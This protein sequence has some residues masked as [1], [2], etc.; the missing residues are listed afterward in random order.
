M[1][2]ILHTGVHCT[3]DDKLLKGL[4][5]NADAFRADGVAIPGPSRYRKLLSQLINTL[6]DNAPAPDAREILLDALLSVDAD[7]V[8]RL[9]LSHENLFTVPKQALAGGRLY[10][11]AEQRIWNM[12]DLFVGDGIELHMGL[13]NPA[14]FLPAVYARTPHA[15]FD[16]FMCG[17]DPMHLRWS[18]LITRIR[19]E[20]PD[21]ALT[22][23]CNE[24]TPL[25]WG[26]I[27]REMAGIELNRKIIGSFDLLQEIMDPEGM[28]RFRAYLKDH[29]HINEM[30]KRRVMVAFLDK[31]AMDEEIE[32]ELDLP[33][34]DEAY[35][36]MLTELYEEDVYDISRMSGVT[37]IAP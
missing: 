32:E 5:R 23:W 4:L 35:V 18:D 26:Q 15:S 27:M 1:Q 16:A 31:Y 2:V 29:P 14:T 17:V 30:Q 7:Q 12:K 13:R 11:K 10:R 21:V 24:D 6:G 36:D 9:I 3:D 28:K 34:W 19:T 20:H 8:D 22:I 25:I 37:V 33:G